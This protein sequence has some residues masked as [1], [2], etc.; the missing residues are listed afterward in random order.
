MITSEAIKNC[1]EAIEAKERQF[2]ECRKIM[3]EHE[4]TYQ[5]LHELE[6]M[7]AAFQII[8]GESYIDY[9]IRQIEEAQE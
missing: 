3:K 1:A 7:K 9:F 2:V 5:Y 4:L 6:G 8:T